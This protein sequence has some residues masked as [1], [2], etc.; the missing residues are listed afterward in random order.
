MAE[1]FIRAGLFSGAKYQLCPWPQKLPDSSTES[2]DSVEDTLTQIVQTYDPNLPPLNVEAIQ[3]LTHEIEQFLQSHSGQK[4]YW[5]IQL[6][7]ESL[8]WVV[9]FKARPE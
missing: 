8:A 9:N 2:P 4:F 7:V 6:D 5:R 3:G 1:V